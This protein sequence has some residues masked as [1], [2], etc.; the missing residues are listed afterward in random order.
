MR[1]W[2]YLLG[3]ATSNAPHFKV[4]D[5][6]TLARPFTSHKETLEVPKRRA[7]A[8][9][10]PFQSGDC[11]GAER[12]GGF[13]LSLIIDW[14][15]Q[16]GT[17]TGAGQPRL[18]SGSLWSNRPYSVPGARCFPQCVQLPEW[19]EQKPSSVMSGRMLGVSTPVTLGQQVPHHHDHHDFCFQTSAL[20]F[21]AVGSIKMSSIQA[22][23][24]I[25][26]MGL[27]R[28]CLL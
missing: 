11:L 13:S 4:F 6:I 5:F 23:K 24:K 19:G 17:R 18:R 26:L 8:S 28:E 2:V 12:V 3:T 7:W 15:Q 22:P 1:T 27:E 25:L 21:L 10:G 16:F 14:R 20:C 9:L